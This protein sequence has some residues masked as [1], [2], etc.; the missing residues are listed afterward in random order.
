MLGYIERDLKANLKSWFFLLSLIIAAGSIIISTK[1]NPLA[2]SMYKGMSLFLVGFGYSSNSMFILI[3]PLIVAITVFKAF[4]KETD[5]NMLSAILVRLGKR[6]YFLTKTMSVGI[7]GALVLGLPLIGLLLINW[8]IY[9]DLSQVD[10]PIYGP[11]SIIANQNQ[12]LYAIV[13]IINSMVVGFILANISLLVALITNKKYAALIM[14]FLIYTLPNFFF[15][16]VGLYQFTP[17]NLL[18]PSWATKATE[19]SHS[20]YLALAIFFVIGIGYYIFVVRDSQYVS[21]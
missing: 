10:L 18:Y 9:P 2:I 7:T 14:P 20:L 1:G 16:L 8:L 21:E 19:L 5:N 15:V 11:F 4:T 12:L 13:M 6:R 3:A 17:S